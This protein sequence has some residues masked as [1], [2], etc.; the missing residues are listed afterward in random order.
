[1]LSKEDEENDD[2]EMLKKIINIESAHPSTKEKEPSAESNQPTNNPSAP[3]AP[4]ETSSAQSAPSETPSASLAPSETPSAAPSTSSAPIT[5]SSVPNNPTPL[6]TAI[7]QPSASVSTPSIVNPSANTYAE[8]ITVQ[9]G[10]VWD[11]FVI[12]IP[13]LNGKTLEEWYEIYGF[14]LDKLSIKDQAQVMGL[15]IEQ[16]ERDKGVIEP[17]HRFNE[18][19]LPRKRTTMNEPPPFQRERIQIGKFESNFANFQIDFSLPKRIDPTPWRIVTGPEEGMTVLNNKNEVQFIQSKYMHYAPLPLLKTMWLKCCDDED[20]EEFKQKIMEGILN[21]GV[22]DIN[23]PIFD[24]LQKSE[25]TTK[26]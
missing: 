16:I 14:A 23:D 11:Q 15:A 4:S 3:S 22:E 26:D 9:E 17:L 25:M 12:E 2:D 18:D 13:K 19:N 10:N 20:A 7:S 5:S 1:M 6:P 21:N 24:F 8:I